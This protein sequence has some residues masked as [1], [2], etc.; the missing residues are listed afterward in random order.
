MIYPSIFTLAFTNYFYNFGHLTLYM[1]TWELI[2]D[3]QKKI[4]WHLHV[5][6][7]DERVPGD[8]VSHPNPVGN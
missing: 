3:I 6:S 5:A 7:N 4:N 1:L 8:L 2:S